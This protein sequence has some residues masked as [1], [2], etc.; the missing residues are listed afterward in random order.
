MIFYFIIVPAKNKDFWGHSALWEKTE[1]KEDMDIFLFVWKKK[2]KIGIGIDFGKGIGSLSQFGIEE[3]KNLIIFL[4]HTFWS[5]CNKPS[6]VNGTRWIIT[7][8]GFLA[9]R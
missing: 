4:I 6:L 1:G 2:K 8:F 7:G 5:V 3:M 9:G